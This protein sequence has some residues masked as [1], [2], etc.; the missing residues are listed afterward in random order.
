MRQR[1]ADGAAW[2]RFRMDTLSRRHFMQRASAI[3]LGFAGL[4]SGI[5]SR[6]IA[7]AMEDSAG[8]GD[9]VPDPDG[10]LDLPAGFS[11]S[12]VMRHGDRMDDGFTSPGLPDGMAA[13]PAGPGRCV[14]VRNHEIEAK[15]RTPR[16]F[17]GVDAEMIESV[18]GKLFDHGYGRPSP[19]GTTNLVYNTDEQRLEKSFLSITGTERNC[20]GGPTPWGTW[21]T[22]EESVSKKDD[23][24]FEKD[25]GWVFEVPALT[26]PGLAEPVP[27][28]A[29]GRFNHEAVA[30]SPGGNVYQTEDR[31]DGLLYRYVPNTPGQLR[32]GGRLQMLV[33]K[34]KPSL[35]TRNWEGTTVKIGEIFDCEWLDIEEVESP[36]DT[37]RTEGFAAGAAR[38][39]RGEGMW[40]GSD[41]VYFCCTNGGKAKAGQIF[42]LKFDGSHGDAERVT[43]EL[44]IQP[45]D[46]SVLEN[47]DNVT[48]APSGPL[49]GHLVVCEDGSGDQFLVLVS[50]KG[51]CSKL[52]RNAISSSEFAGAAFSPD[53]STLF[54]NIQKDGLTLAITGPWGA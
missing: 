7:T 38:F 37:L 33:V 49:D 40:A 1:A 28:K 25:H 14:L 18:R 12:I 41:G 54:V 47:A 42:R 27:I 23:D 20:A 31:H 36:G 35:D 10:I 8:F 43:L 2:V 21:L 44:F 16:A 9:L 19:G 32:N 15:H 11:Y 26:E 53:G 52:A 22:C 30:V 50:P 5:A 29:M 34:G 6:G 13:F 17:D 51:E 48:V 45:D 46:R 3:S 39:A 24:T 4:S